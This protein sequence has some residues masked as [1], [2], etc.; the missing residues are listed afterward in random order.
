MICFASAG[1][2]LCE[3]YSK[4][5]IMQLPDL[6]ITDIAVGMPSLDKSFAEAT[7]PLKVTVKNFGA[8]TDQSFEI[9][10]EVIDSSGRS[11][12]PFIVSGQKDMFFP[13]KSGLNRGETYTFK[14]NLTIG[15]RQGPSLSGKRITIIACADSC[16]EDGSM[17][18]YCRVKETNE[19]NNEMNKVINLPVQAFHH[20]GTGENTSGTPSSDSASIPVTHIFHIPF[21]FVDSSTNPGALYYVNYTDHLGGE[22]FHRESGH[23]TSFAFHPS[24]PRKLY[25]ANANDNRIFLAVK[26]ASGKW[27]EQVVYTH[28]TYVKDIAFHSDK[29]G[30]LALY[31][32]EASGAGG[33]GRIF[34]LV[35]GTA[36]PFY[37]VLLFNMKGFWRGD[38]TFD[39]AG[40][41]YLSSGNC[42]PARIYKEA[43]NNISL[44]R[45]MASGFIFEDDNESISG[46]AFKDGALYYA[47][48]NN[49]IYRLDLAN[50]IRTKYTDPSRRSISDIGFQDFSASSTTGGARPYAS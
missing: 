25:Y 48:G 15:S 12:K 2:A 7:I 24:V 21:Y 8:E 22:I 27:S 18:G 17:P 23:I 6:R 36:V 14:G 46:M 42:R 50:G 47:N 32:S 26:L 30:D 20:T 10:I 33:N 1:N 45:E 41:L 37:D 44:P 29:D 49:T 40:N 38:F 3:D 43:F 28:N 4:I 39:D 11:V 31:F 16:L 5:G 19:N 34:K 13:Q 35:N 9:S